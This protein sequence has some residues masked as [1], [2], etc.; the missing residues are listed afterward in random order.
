MIFLR[1][2]EIVLD[3]NDIVGLLQGKKYYYFDGEYGHTILLGELRK[4]N[5][6]VNTN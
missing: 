3:M 6:D 5:E 4:E 1:N 2:D